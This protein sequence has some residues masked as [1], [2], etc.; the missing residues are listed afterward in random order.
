[1]SFEK[2]LQELGSSISSRLRDNKNQPYQSLVLFGIWLKRNL[3]KEEFSFL[4][5][6]EEKL[7]E[8][9]ANK[10]LQEAMVASGRFRADGE[11]VVAVDHTHTLDQVLENL[12]NN[13]KEALE[14]LRE[15]KK[16]RGF[17]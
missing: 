6:I 3:S 15:Y 7:G 9:G 12:D 14:G 2:K 5:E 8:G 10:W 16:E 11:D 1:M 13:P 4:D 17:K